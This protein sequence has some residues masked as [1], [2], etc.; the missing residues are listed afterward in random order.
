MNSREI[1]DELFEIMCDG[2]YIEEPAGRGCGY[3]FTEEGQAEV[4]EVI[5]RILSQTE[6]ESIMNTPQYAAVKTIR[7]FKVTAIETVQKA[8]KGTNMLIEDEENVLLEEKLFKGGTKELALFDAMNEVKK[9]AKVD[10]ANVRWDC[11]P[12]PG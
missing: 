4:M 1:A 7:N 3:G 9:D 12:F 6:K 2:N 8:H 5:K 11:R 10:M